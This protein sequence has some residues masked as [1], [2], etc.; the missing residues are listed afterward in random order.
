MLGQILLGIQ[1]GQQEDKMVHQQLPEMMARTGTITTTTIAA[2]N[3]NRRNMSWFY[4]FVT[5]YTV[6]NVYG[7]TRVESE[8]PPPPTPPAVNSAVNSEEAPAAAA[9]T[10]TRRCI[11]EHLVDFNAPPFTST[12]PKGPCGIPMVK[13]N[14]TKMHRYSES[15]PSSIGN[16]QIIHS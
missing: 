13:F 1:R 8:S 4:C 10:T 5:K 12:L 6:H 9:A 15:D 16:V 7:T 2:M 14:S 3:S 11:R